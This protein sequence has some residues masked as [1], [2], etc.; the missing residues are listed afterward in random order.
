MSYMLQ[1]VKVSELKPDDRILHAG[2]LYDV[3]AYPIKHAE[4][5]WIFVRGVQFKDTDLLAFGKDDCVQVYTS[6]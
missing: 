5:T 2:D 6:L 1:A 4:E 3:R